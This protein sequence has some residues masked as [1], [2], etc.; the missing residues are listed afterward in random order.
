M[1]KRISMNCMVLLAALGKISL[2]CGPAS[3]L[4]TTEMTSQSTATTNDLLLDNE[5]GFNETTE[6]LAPSAV[7]SSTNGM[8]FNYKVSQ[9]SHPP[10]QL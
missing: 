9:F 1:M 6:L 3:I 5:S 2:T 8:L 4:L 10:A 7:L